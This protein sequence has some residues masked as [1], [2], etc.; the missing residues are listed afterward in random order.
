LDSKFPN[1][2]YLKATDSAIASIVLEARFEV[3]DRSELRLLLDMPDDELTDDTIYDLQPSLVAKIVSNYGLSFEPG[4]MPVELHPW[5]PIDDRPYTIHTNRELLLML[6]GTKPL[7]VFSDDYPCLHGHYIIPERE[8][9]PHLASGLIVKREQIIP[10]QPDDPVLNGPRIGQRRVLYALKGEEWRIDAYIL[11]WETAD[12]SGWNAGFE[13]MEGSLLG[14][15]DWQNDFHMREWKPPPRIV[16]PK[17][18]M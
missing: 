15:E 9:E 7:A 17:K 3:K 11:L 16:T 6:A 14:Y 8:F 13:R 5:H 4:S 18:D 10:P 2:F 1:V 12:K